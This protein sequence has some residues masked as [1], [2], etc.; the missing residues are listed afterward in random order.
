M[1]EKII[2]KIKKLLALSKSQNEHESQNAMLKVQEMLMKHKL[3][4]K[5][6][7][8]CELEPITTEERETGFTFTKAKWKGKLGKL[9]GDNLSCYT[10]F[11]GYRSYQVVFF[12]KDDDVAIAEITYKYAID[13]INSEVGKLRRQ[14]YKEYG[15]SIGIENDYAL[16]F[17]S[18]LETKFNEQKA[19]HQEWGIVL[20]KPKEVVE[21]YEEMSKGFSKKSLSLSTQYKGNSE[22]Y[23]KGEKDGKEFD[24]TNKIASENEDDIKLIG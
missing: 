7:E 23:Y 15:T 6:V 16:G 13:C 4:L 3:S 10:F 18:G 20:S 12:G 14:A 17:I 22:A 2:S 8:E 24:I 11:R 1:N 9:I 21:Q 5:D 19:K